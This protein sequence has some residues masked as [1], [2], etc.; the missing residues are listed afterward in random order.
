MCVAEQ[1]YLR[2]RDIY[3]AGSSTATEHDNH[4]RHPPGSAALLNKMPSRAEEQSTNEALRQRFRITTAKRNFSPTSSACFVEE[5]AIHGAKRGFGAKS[6]GNALPNER[7]Q[8][9][10]CRVKKIFLKEP[11][12]V[13]EISPPASHN[14]LFSKVAVP[15]H[16]C[17][18]PPQFYGCG[19]QRTGVVASE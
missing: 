18:G 3:A 13:E 9:P 1:L 2:Y 12:H 14:K 15:F 6:G 7:P 19:S 11:R 10:P 4:P 5:T 17:C 16:T 8:F